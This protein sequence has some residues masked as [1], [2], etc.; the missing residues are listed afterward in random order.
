MTKL[1]NHII[2]YS[3]FSQYDIELLKQYLIVPIKSYE[4]YTLFAICNASQKEYLNSF[5]VTK[6]LEVEKNEI[7]FFLS[8]LTIRQNLYDLYE[9]T[10]FNEIHNQDHINE[11][12]KALL[13][14][15]IVKKSSDIHFE[16]SQDG[17]VIRF[18]IDGSMKTFFKFEKRLYSIV[19][20][21]IKLLCSLDIT[22]KRK[23]LDGRFSL[24]IESKKVDFRVSTM[25]TLNGESI[26]LRVLEPFDEHKQLD[27]LGFNK[28]QLHLLKHAMI[29]THGLILITGPTGSGKTTTLYSILK[30][31]N[32]EEKKIITVE[33]P[34]EYQLHDIQQIAVNHALG[35]TY[36]TI[37]KNILRQDPDIIMIGE[38][39]DK[40]SLD[41]ALQASM[42]GH[43]VLATLHTNNCIQTLN[44]LMDLDAKPYVIAST[45]K[46]IISQRL[47]LK[48]CSCEM[49]CD[50][51]NYTLFNGRLSLCEVLNVDEDIESMISKKQSNQDI[52]NA[53]YTKGFKSLLEDGKSKAHENLTT[54]EEV[55]KAV[56]LAYE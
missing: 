29:K 27:S 38:I 53:A 24:D 31:L 42:T 10:I 11:F 6:T 39:R 16:T 56:G 32:Q 51:C 37:L 9:K 40:E 36:T 1:K 7:L 30:A 49:G 28:E 33:D 52:L 12:I 17:F 48:T 4:F 14:F 46:M 18:R 45:L 43:L 55:Y 41:I 20:S 34:V 35:L 15:A 19:G 54:Y 26:V 23:P 22:Q 25:P 21:V 2:H 13:H 44:R 3:L 47:V 8:D 5:G 50:K